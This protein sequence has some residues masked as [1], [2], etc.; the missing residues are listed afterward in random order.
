MRKTLG[1][2]LL[3]LLLTVSA[4]AG[5]MPNLEP[6]PPPTANAAQEPNTDGD[7]STMSAGSLTQTVLDLLAALPSLL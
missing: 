3:V 6:A 2:S 4:N 5:I 7:I 1:V